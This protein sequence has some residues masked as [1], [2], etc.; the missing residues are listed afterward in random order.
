MTGS[1]VDLGLDCFQ[2]M[3]RVSVN[4]EYLHSCFAEHVGRG[5]VGYGAPVVV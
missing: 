4:E 1:A 5:L 3:G 2:R